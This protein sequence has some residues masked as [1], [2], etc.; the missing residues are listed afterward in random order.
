MAKKKNEESKGRILVRDPR[1]RVK[2]WVDVKDVI[3]P[4]PTTIKTY[5]D[6][7]PIGS[8]SDAFASQL[9]H[10]LKPVEK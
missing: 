2:S 6:M 9:L 4:E 1:T 8:Y 3:Y 5:R 7:T 10:D